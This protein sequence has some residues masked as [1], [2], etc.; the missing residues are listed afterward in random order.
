[1]GV[2]LSPYRK[3][4]GKLRS[5]STEVKG[6]VRRTKYGGVT[7]VRHHIRNVK[8]RDY[9]KEYYEKRRMEKLRRKWEREGIEKITE[10]MMRKREQDDEEKELEEKQDKGMKEIAKVFFEGAAV[11]FLTVA[12]PGSAQLIYGGYRF[13]K[14]MKLGKKI[15][16]YY[17]EKKDDKD[18]LEK[19]QIEGVKFILGEKASRIY[20]PYAIE[21]AKKLTYSG[22]KSGAFD[23][24]SKNT[25]IEREVYANMF[26]GSVAQG[27]SES[28]GELASFTVETFLG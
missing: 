11:G 12:A 26:E 21:N 13:Y 5:T 7:F 23:E 16:D 9:H 10:E 15:I 18:F 25:G 17:S 6:H 20:E 8:K 2:C 14:T 4:K 22:M 3:R 19:A 27:L 1:M 24:I 28:A